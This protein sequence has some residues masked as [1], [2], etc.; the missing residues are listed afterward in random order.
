MVIT[1]KCRI[2][3][4]NGSSEPTHRVHLYLTYKFWVFCQKMNLDA[5][6]CLNRIISNKATKH[7]IG[8]KVYLIYI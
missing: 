1:E 7:V 8:D 4:F 5:N 2:N 3:C 6:P